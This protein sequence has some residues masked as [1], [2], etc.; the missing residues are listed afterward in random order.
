MPIT[1]VPLSRTGVVSFSFTLE[2][3]KLVDELHGHMTNTKLD[4]DS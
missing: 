3:Y 4:A 2:L 1:S